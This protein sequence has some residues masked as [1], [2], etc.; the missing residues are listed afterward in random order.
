MIASDWRWFNLYGCPFNKNGYDPWTRVFYCVQGYFQEDN[1]G[2]HGLPF[3][4]QRVL[5]YIVII[6][7]S[8]ETATIRRSCLFKLAS[9]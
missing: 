3:I 1:D 7:I 4:N 2:L 8:V 9:R 6:A 5:F